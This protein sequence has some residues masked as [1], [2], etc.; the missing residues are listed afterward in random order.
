MADASQAQ[1]ML[2]IHLAGFGDLIM[3]LPALVS[4]RSRFPQAKLILLTWKRHAAIAER[5]S[6][7]DQWC[8]LEDS[9]ALGA[10]LRNLCTL[11]SLRR[12]R[13]DAAINVCQLYRRLGI[14]KLRL[15]L[16]LIGPGRTV[17]RNTDGKGKWFDTF[18]DEVQDQGSHEVQRQMAV[19]SALE[20]AEAASAFCEQPLRI[21][22]QDEASIISWLTA[23]GV[24]ADEPLLAL[25]AGSGRATHRWPWQKFAQT[26]QQLERMHGMRVVLIGARSERSLARRIA[27]KLEHPVIAAGEL[28]F[29][30]LCALF[31]R[32]RLLVANDS[33]PVHLACFLNLPLVVIMGPTDPKRYGLHPI[34]RTNQTLI[35]AADCARCY[36]NDCGGHAALRQLPVEMVLEAALS[37]LKGEPVQE[38]LQVQVK[39]RILH[40]HTLPVISGSG[41]NTFLCMQGARDAGFD[42]ALACAP[43]GDLIRKVKDAGMHVHLLRHMVWAPNPWR[44]AL[45][46]LELRRLIR[47]EGYGVVHTHNSKA[48]FIGRLAARVSGTEVIVHT[49]HG[50]AFHDNEKPRRR[51]LYR[52]LERLAARW[53]DRMIMISQPLMDWALAEGIAPREKMVK[54]YS[55]ID[56]ESFRGSCDTAAARASLGL[57]SE[58]FVVGEVAKLWAGKGH[59]ILLRSAALLRSRIPHLKVVLIGDGD[60]RPSLERLVAALHLEQ[61]VV[62]AGFREDV[63]VLTRMLDVAVLPSLFE[64]MGRAVIEAQAAARAVIGTRVGGIPDLI[65]DGQTGLLID[66]GSVEALAD[67]IRRLFEDAPLRARLGEQAQR[68]IDG[69]FSSRTMVE[70]TI[71]VYQELLQQK[72]GWR[73]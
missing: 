27:A 53:C 71:G 17:G 61:R 25:H 39:K 28:S 43:G 7:I 58:D 21:T 11:L 54:I 31:S 69:R 8:C 30:Q 40:V 51:Q 1:T 9:A 66:P 18:V 59:D 16:G 44:D 35:H 12:K 68:S 4:L 63:P 46:V 67:A 38:L 47:R 2:V 29:G 62:F 5:L 13:V 65:Q 3:G 32:V 22:A 14:W 23:R 36:R 15:L 33:G 60:L 10:L 73:G 6:M 70:Q 42:A 55:G 34:R 26:A 49:V 64:G 19:I 72:R 56:M 52:I 37:I 50:F 20:P 45:A 57:G 41:I 24:A 48:G